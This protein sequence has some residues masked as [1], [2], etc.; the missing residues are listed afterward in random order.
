MKPGPLRKKAEDLIARYNVKTTS[1]DSP[2]EALS[3]GNVQRAILARELF[4]RCRR[5]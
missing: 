1:P 4:G 2:I 5:A 3:G